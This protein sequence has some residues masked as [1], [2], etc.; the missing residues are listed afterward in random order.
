MIASLF[1]EYVDKYFSRVVGKIV[2]KFNGKQKEE[3]LLHKTMLTEE[4]SPDLK[5]GSTELNHSVVSADVVALD[6]P[7]PLKKRDRLSNATGDLP[8]LGV[9]YRK[10]E[11]LITDINVAKARNADEATIVAK[12][13]DDASKCIRSMDVLKEVLFRRG[14]STGQLLVTEDDTDGTGVRVSYGY[15]EDHIFKCVGAPWLDTDDD[16]TPQDDLQQLFDKAQED[17]NTIAHVY[18]T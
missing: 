2:E 10:G 17:G 7:L 13:F 15:R 4:Y 3:T 5:W 14:L 6:S 16:P 11:K 18:L 9:K 1:A 8:K 12:I